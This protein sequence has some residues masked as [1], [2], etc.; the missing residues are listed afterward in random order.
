MKRYCISRAFVIVFLF[1]NAITMRAQH[2][3]AMV[4][5]AEGE[6]WPSFAEYHCVPE[7]GTNGVDYYRI[8]DWDFYIRKEYYNPI[9]LPFGYRLAEKSIF[10]Y[11]FETEEEQ[12]AFDFSLS[13]GEH[14]VTYNG[15]EWMVEAVADTLVNTSYQGK[16]ESSSKRLLKVHSIDGRYTDQWL[17]DF[18]S[19]SNHFMIQ[20]IDESTQTWTLWMEYDE[21][22]Y[23]V[24]EISSDPLFV[25]DSGMPEKNAL[26]G[27]TV[28]T[29]TYNDGALVVEYSGYHSP[30]RQLT[31]F[32]RVG[33]DFYS[34]YVWDL[35][36][37]TS[38]AYVVWHQYSFSLNGLPA[39]GSGNYTIH[40]NQGDRP[41]GIPTPSNVNEI[42]VNSKCVDLSGRQIRH[43][44]FDTHHLPHGIYI[45]DGKKVAGKRK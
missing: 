10:I 12:L 44:S 35:N 38:S 19:L 24:Q 25:S 8:Y 34:A 42:S 37:G 31:C 28:I 14:F 16:G 5:L 9:R 26:H 40:I 22:R 32:Y 17:E 4:T 29:S 1:A 11:D 36:P 39:P 23:L 18:G 43:T 20:P 13:V 30:N 41:L 2:S 45:R 3:W 33:D 15:I 21:G 7:K 6:N 27:E